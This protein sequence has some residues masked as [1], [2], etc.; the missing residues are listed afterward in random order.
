MSLQ[1][2]FFQE[3]RDI[4]LDE[5]LWIHLKKFRE[6]DGFG[7]QWLGISLDFEFIN[8]PELKKNELFFFSLFYLVEYVI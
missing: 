8:R 6:I 3:N 4:G 2:C 7:T 5:D 1:S